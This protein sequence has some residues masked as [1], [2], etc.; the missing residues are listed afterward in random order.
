MD[1]I[2]EIFIQSAKQ[3]Q[4]EVVIKESSVNMIKKAFLDYKLVIS[5]TLIVIFTFILFF[6]SLLVNAAVTMAHEQAH[7]QGCIYAGG[8]AEVSWSVFFVSAQT[9]CYGADQEYL[10]MLNT[11]QEVSDYPTIL[12]YIGIVLANITLCIFVWIMF[13]WSS[14]TR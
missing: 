13:V 9:A 2:T 12:I 4:K 3:T 10:K 8:T 6:E 5:M 7:A 1:E 11:I 14:F